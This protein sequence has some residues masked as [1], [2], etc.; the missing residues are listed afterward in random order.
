[1]KKK[2]FKYLTI[3]TVIMIFL[4]FAFIFFLMHYQQSENRHQTRN[5]GQAVAYSVQQHITAAEGILYSLA[6]N[7]EIDAN[8]DQE[9]FELLASKY[10]EREPNI[11]FIQHK[12]KETITDMVFPST[13]SY[14]LGYSLFGREEVEEAVYKAI[15]ERIATANDPFILQNTGDVLGLVMRYPLYRENKFDGFFV[16]TFD[17]E[18]YIDCITKE[19]VPASYNIS[20]HD[21]DGNLFWGE[22]KEDEKNSYVTDIQIMD[23]Y[24]TMKI[25]KNDKN[26]TK[27]ELLIGMISIV[28]LFLMSILSYM[29]VGLLKKDKDIEYLS[30]LHKELER[31]KESYTLALDSANDALWEWDL[32]TDKIITS[33]KWLEITGNEFTGNGLG[34]IL[35]KEKIHQDDYDKVLRI[36]QMC[37][38]GTFHEFYSEYRIKDKYHHYTWV[39]NK[40]KVYFNSEG[41]ISKIA[42]AVSNIEERK[43]KESKIE[44]MAYYDTLTN[45]PNKIQF[46]NTLENVLK[47]MAKDSD[48][49]AILMID[50][51][52]FRS[53]NDLL[54]L[55]FCDAL[56]KNVGHRMLSVVGRENMVAR[57]GGD[58][59]LLLI[60]HKN[61]KAEIEELCQTILNIFEKP[62]ILKG[63]SVYLTV[64]IGVVH[65]LER[66]QTASDIIRNADTALNKAKEKGKKRYCFYDAQM[67]HEIFRRS[68]VES[69]IRKA[70]NEDAFIIHY[71]PQ[72]DLSTDEI[73]GVE[74]LARL[75]SKELGMISPFEFI[76]VAEYTGL[77]IPLGSW[78]LKNACIQGKAWIDTGYEIDK[79]SV[80]ISA[81]QLHDES[82]YRTVQEIL[83]QTN[84]PVEKL[85]LEIT[86]SVL[87][88]SSRNNIDTLKKLK[89]LGMSIA[90]DDFGTGYSSL[91]YLTVLPIDTL[92]IDKSFV[93]KVIEN[94]TELQV[95][96]SIVELAHKL[97]LKVVSEGVETLDQKQILGSMKCD[98]I[99]GYY[100]AKPSDAESV[101]KWFIRR[102]SNDLFKCV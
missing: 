86:E 12:N 52:N 40:G 92:K 4:F 20:L 30:N 21:K 65:S 59:F 43:Q 67:H 94:E 53:H 75:S 1:M 83:Q 82:F 25:Y 26:I 13:Y 9:K 33:D 29:Q 46:M 15:Q 88:N 98:Y 74:A 70:L 18:A 90:L 96:K 23:N 62:F 42:G 35:Q 87:L 68:Q 93:D 10:M 48:P 56:L 32:I 31:L 102:G 6:H 77:I 89:Q 60:H 76:T 36:F 95:I 14:T 100:I 51:D 2:L 80:N 8:M 44:Y 64:S 41:T 47:D 17:L 49:Y 81:N 97:D 5:I 11:L 101:E 50:L 66:G 22:S 34:A 38:E 28:L 79:I 19:V 78:M 57:F 54:G 61:C 73:R 39:Q 91:N 84:F 7:Y 72:Q 16:I 55:E 63:N 24:W 58:E 69:C 85:E 45:L 99:Q 71:Q 37:L 3:Q 27:Q